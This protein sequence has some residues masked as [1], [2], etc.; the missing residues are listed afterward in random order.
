MTTCKQVCKLTKDPYPWNDACFL[1]VFHHSWGCSAALANAYM[2]LR[3]KKRRERERERERER[4]MIMTHFTVTFYICYWVVSIFYP[5]ITEFYELG[6]ALTL[7]PIWLPHCPAWIWT[8]SLMLLLSSYRCCNVEQWRGQ[9]L[10]PV[11]FLNQ[12]MQEAQYGAKANSKYTTV[13]LNRNSYLGWSCDVVCSDLHVRRESQLQVLRYTGA[14][15]RQ[16]EWVT[17]MLCLAR[18]TSLTHSV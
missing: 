4:S 10:D 16:C 6:G 15:G 2:Y 11:Q 8:I 18:W 14:A 5:Q 17:M 1:I 12:Q 3:R 7:D 13:D 9:K